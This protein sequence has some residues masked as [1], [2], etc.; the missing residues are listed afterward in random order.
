MVESQHS[1]RKHMNAQP[2]ARSEPRDPEP[3]TGE[4]H[5]M[6]QMAGVSPRQLARIA[7]GLYLINIVGGSFAFGYPDALVVPGDAA[8]STQYPGA[9]TA[10]S[11]EPRGPSHRGPDQH[12]YGG[13]LL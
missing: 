5:V 9:R 8:D 3:R 12:P 2:G 7:G 13:H 4:A 10:L 1:W 11:V 6:N